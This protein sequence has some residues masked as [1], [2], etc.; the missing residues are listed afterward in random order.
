MLLEDEPAET[1]I[2][3]LK[4]ASRELI[5]FLGET[6]VGFARNDARTGKKG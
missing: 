5:Q 4:E 6:Q 2:F 3:R 1:R